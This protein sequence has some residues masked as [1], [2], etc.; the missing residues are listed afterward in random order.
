MVVRSKSARGFSALSE[1]G[2]RQGSTTDS[3]ASEVRLVDSS[4]IL[5]VFIEIN[6]FDQISD[7]HL[8]RRFLSEDG[9]TACS[10]GGL[11]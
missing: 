7:H 6:E 9:S 2:D 10:L 8:F 3:P 11:A 5:I 4:A 1:S